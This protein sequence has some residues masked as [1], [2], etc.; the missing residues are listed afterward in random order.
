MDASSKDCLLK[1]QALASGH[2]CV[3]SDLCLHV[4]QG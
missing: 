1:P 4:R 3:S 2:T